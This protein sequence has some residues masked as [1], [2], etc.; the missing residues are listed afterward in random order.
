MSSNE[1]QKQLMWKIIHSIYLSWIW[2][3]M[4]LIIKCYKF[5]QKQ[6]K[7]VGTKEPVRGGK[8]T[9]RLTFHLN[10]KMGSIP[11]LDHV[12]WYKGWWTNKMWKISQI[13]GSSLQF[14]WWPTD[15]N[16]DTDDSEMRMILRW[17]IVWIIIRDI[18]DSILVIV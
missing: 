3:F 6:S 16:M 2:M 17:N 4:N 12:I 11:W 10:R 5:F 7:I 8:I 15:P 9:R 13:F 14:H 1:I 18:D